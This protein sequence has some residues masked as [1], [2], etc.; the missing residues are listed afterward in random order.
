MSANPVHT[1]V[2]WRKVTNTGTVP[3]NPGVVNKY[4]GSTVNTPSLTIN[5]AD[6]TD[7]GT[8]ICTATNAVG[9]GQSQ[10]TTLTVTGSKL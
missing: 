7:S 10:Q 8:Y 2:E 1:S 4:S 3:V 6:N 5:N 9:T